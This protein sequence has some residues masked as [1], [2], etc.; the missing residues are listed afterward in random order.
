MSET[1]APVPIVGG[2]VSGGS[3]VSV[4]SLCRRML[5]RDCDMR[6]L[7]LWVRPPGPDTIRSIPSTERGPGHLRQGET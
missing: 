5:R 3:H 2:G 4:M 7:G 6:F 1:N